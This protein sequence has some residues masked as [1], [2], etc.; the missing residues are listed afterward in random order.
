MVYTL[1]GFDISVDI[2]VS[3]LAVNTILL[4]IAIVGFTNLR[5]QIREL[6]ASIDKISRIQTELRQ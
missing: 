6:K 2:I 3:A 4:I 5:G 1:F